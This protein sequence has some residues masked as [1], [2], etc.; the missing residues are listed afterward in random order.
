MSKECKNARNA[1]L[2]TIIILMILV[3]FC[4]SCGTTKQG[5]GC[6]GS[7]IHLGN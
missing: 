4:S 2:G 3:V 6:G 1:V 5:G 7:P